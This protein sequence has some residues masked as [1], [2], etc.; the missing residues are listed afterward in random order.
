MNLIVHPA[1]RL[2]GSLA[3]PGDKSISHRA[4]IL[5]ALAQ[6]ESRINNFL[7]GGDCWAT[8]NCLQA[9]GVPVNMADPTTVRIE[10]V[11][12]NG[13][14]E[15]ANPLDCINSGTT[16]R[17]L[18]GLLA[19]QAF[20]SILTGSQ[21]LLRRPM[22]RITDP[23]RQMG[24]TVLGRNKGTL[25]PLAFQSGSVQA[26]DYAMPVASAQVKSAILLA[27]LFADGLTVV[28]EPGPARD[29]TE[30]MLKSLGVP[31]HVWGSVIS[32]ERPKAS[33][34][35]LHI[36][37]PGDISSAA[38]LLAA[39]VILPDAQVTVTRVGVNPRRTGLLDI[40]Q[41]MGADIA[42]ENLREDTGEPM[43]DVTARYSTLRGV[44]VGGQLIVRSIDELPVLAVLATQ[45][46]GR[47]QVR[48]AAELRV[49]ETDRIAV[50]VRELRRLGAHIEEQPDGFIVE[51]PTALGSAPVNSHGDH[52]LAMALAVAA[53]V[54]SGPV[55]IEQAECFAD[56]YP[57]FQ[58]AL[59][60][61]GVEVAEELNG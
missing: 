24:A 30:R 45:A 13:L 17:L 56:S 25:A 32:V 34:P 52:R 43:A 48:D 18:A 2:W 6:G 28:R 21:Q 39:A 54:A 53:L 49:K 58:R 20:F 33:W 23:L 31:V 10:G 7:P 38:F 9:L 41:A 19:G 44:E 42:I 37:V 5:G 47:T 40:L 15:P 12:L 55:L 22:G 4:A 16:M 26:I 8:L 35:P 61:L 29:H 50:L 51:G 1:R 14:Q 11:G 60:K 57:G 27:G 36:T 46:N 3:V 59:Q